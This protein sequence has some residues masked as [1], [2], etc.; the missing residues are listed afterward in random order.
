MNALL[1]FAFFAVALIYSS[2]GFGGGSSYT[3]LL[4]AIGA[5]FA[6]IP[7]ISLACNIIV[8]SGNSINFWRAKQFD[9]R[10]FW[11]LAI[12]SIPFAYLG[13]RLHLPKIAF[14]WI[15]FAA[16][17]ASGIK[18]IF[19]F[20]GAKEFSNFN[21]PS[22]FVLAPI[23]AALGFIA[24]VTGIG[25]GIYLAPVLYF[26]RAAPPKVIA[27]TCSY[28]ILV[29]SVS[30]L[31]GQLQKHHDI[32]LMSQYLLL[33]LAV[34]IG[35]QIGSRTMLRFLPNRFVALLT[36]LLIS[37]VALQIGFKELF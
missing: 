30:G 21:L 27:A 15:L 5:P 6:I 26:M 32:G 18:L 20:W 35:G 12:F 23:G 10:I 36:G 17:L 14:L 1:A 24:G 4:V 29:N 2:V 37:F 31:I 7:A 25:G 28:F 9:L 19:D 33:P 13:G 3:A 22:K 8:V 16:L 11:P 34:L